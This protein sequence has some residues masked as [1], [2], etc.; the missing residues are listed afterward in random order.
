MSL[1]APPG[2]PL[3]L[4]SGSPRRR[5]LLATLGRS[6]TVVPADLDE[7]PLPGESAAHLAERLA[8]EKALAV[9]E[10]LPSD[11]DAL[12]IGSDTVVARGR[13]L[14]GKPATPAEAIEMLEALRGRW[15][16][17]VSAV[18]VV[19]RRTG[20]V[21]SGTE[22]TRVRLRPLTDEEI[23]RY[24]ASGDPMDKA[25]AYAIQNAEFHPV[26]TIV[27]SR[28]NVVGLPLDLLERL[29]RE[30]RGEEQG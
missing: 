11:S 13:R 15:H 14:F 4:A 25:G 18:A 16:R 26:A 29:L 10:R 3:V 6:F 17:V 8:R 7:T 24:V 12:V 23:R 19:D 2:R 22:T 21:G 27:G 30:I 5:A 28:D 9:S 20:R 1:P